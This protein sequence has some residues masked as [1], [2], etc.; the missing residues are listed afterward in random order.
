MKLFQIEEPQDNH[1]ELTINN[2]IG[3]DL[4]TTNSLVA[5][6]RD[7]KPII[8]S[9]NEGQNLVPSL[10]AYNQN[11]IK[12]GNLAKSTNQ[13][14]H[15]ISSI[16]RLMGKAAKDIKIDSHFYNLIN[17]NSANSIHIK[18]GEKLLTP[19]EISSQILLHLKHQAE[20][21][22]QHPVTQAV[23]T[24]PAYF[25]DAAR[26]ATKLAAK[27]A[28][29]DVLRLINEPTAAALA[30]KLEQNPY[31]N[32]LIYDLG[33]GTFDVSLLKIQ[34]GI[35][36]VI[37][38]SGDANLGGDDIDEAIYKYLFSELNS[39]DKQNLLFLSRKL[40]EQLSFK[41]NAIIEYKSKKY[42]LTKSDFLQLINP[43][44][45]TTI[46][47]V[48]NVIEDSELNEHDING[49]ILVGGSTRIPYLKDMLR[50]NFSAK[51]FDDVNP[52][53]IV[54][55]GAAIQAENLTTKTGNLL[56]DVVSLSLGV[57]IMGGMMEKIIDRNSP[58]PTSATQ[59]FTTYQDNQ[60]AMEFH[61]LQGE[62]EMSKDCRSLAVFELKNIPPM[63]AGLARITVT[64][65][66]DADGLLTVKAI[67]ET[68]GTT[69]EIE[70]K[71]SFG[72]SSNEIEEMLLISMQNA[73]EDVIEKLIAETKFEASNLIKSLQQIMLEDKQLLIDG[74]YNKINDNIKLLN[75]AIN[76]TDR[77][78]IN[79]LI[80]QLEL[81]SKDFISRRLDNFLEKKITGK[82]ISDIEKILD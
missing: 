80:E 30:Y 8:I 15:L 65:T 31:G 76:G 6:S 48:S 51:I 62:R 49:I 19:I 52:D 68:T 46:N 37:S 73:K 13:E 60:T 26:N 56:L 64:F 47:I 18:I 74:E 20:K 50:E 55:L 66:I 24:V 21:Y 77:D 71:P 9:D 1:I 40:K 78:L 72:L 36:K 25:D 2:A 7:G 53:E 14:Y 39:E 3:I 5:I 27:L 43:L 59:Q 17:D 32:Y 81:S 16:K 33:G 10:V 75:D 41:D 44:I 61:I 23:I 63:R 57:E 4:G 79:H 29:L 35:F 38:T 28:G 82:K 34:K 42:S 67:E 54:A 69:Q 58:I 12:V 45:T 22:L 70:V 11:D